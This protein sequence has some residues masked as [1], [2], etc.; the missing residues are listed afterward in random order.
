MYAKPSHRQPSRAKKQPAN[1][2]AD[3]DDSSI[4]SDND[5]KDGDF[6]PEGISGKNINIFHYHICGN[7]LY[8]CTEYL[9]AH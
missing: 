6:I 7:M 5:T 4:E 2:L 3:T 8:I 1:Y 9:K